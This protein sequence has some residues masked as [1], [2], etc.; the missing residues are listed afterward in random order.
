ME[1]HGEEVELT[2]TEASGGSTPHIVRYVL[3]IS[4]GLAVVAM[5]VAWMTGSLSTA[6]QDDSIRTG[7]EQNSG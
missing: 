2:T 7:V 4:L 3:A 6:P 5:S 1:R